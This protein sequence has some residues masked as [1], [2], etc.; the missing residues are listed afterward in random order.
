MGEATIP[1][2]KCADCHLQGQETEMFP[3]NGC[4]RSGKRPCS[5]LFCRY[6]C[7]QWA[8]C[9]TCKI[10]KSTKKRKVKESIE[11]SAAKNSHAIAPDAKPSSPSAPGIADAAAMSSDSP[12]LMT[13][14]KASGSP[15]AVSVANF[16][17]MK[18]KVE[19][20]IEVAEAKNSSATAP[21]AKPS[22][23]S[24][25]DPD[26]NAAAMSSD[27][28]VLMAVSKAS[29]SPFPVI[30]SVTQ[31]SSKTAHVNGVRSNIRGRRSSAAPQ[32]CACGCGIPSA[33]MIPCSLGYLCPKAGCANLIRDD[34][35]KTSRT[36]LE[37]RGARSL[38]AYEQHI[39][40]LQG[41]TSSQLAMPYLQS[42]PSTLSL[43]ADFSGLPEGTPFSSTAEQR[44][45]LR[46]DPI[47]DAA[48]QACF[49]DSIANGDN[50][51]IIL[52]VEWVLYRRPAKKTMISIPRQDFRRL[53]SRQ[54]LNDEVT[55]SCI[56]QETL[57]V[58]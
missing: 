49:S 26:T 17:P 31:A 2:I 46:L 19:E 13:V 8:A 9:S 53:R 5:S 4:I 38:Y 42:M 25:P 54:C 12:V 48:L 39:P 24:T 55:H 14:S 57:N 37:H 28:P 44:M 45:Q 35:R 33:A 51:E 15:S 18:R 36:C 29:G 50:D 11:V 22:S 58:A 3:S 20:S 34:C 10:L 30:V 16:S 47:G 27:S 40:S 7:D 56:L 32:L 23:P 1:T 21:D 6:C 52:R 43:L 41:V